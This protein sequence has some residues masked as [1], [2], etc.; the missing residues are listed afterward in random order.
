[1]LDCDTGRLS[2]SEAEALLDTLPGD[3][4]FVGADDRILYFNQPRERLFDRPKAILGTDVRACHPEKSGPTVD[5]V[6]EDLKSGAKD[7][8]E[9]WVTKDGRLIWIR[10]FAVRN[11]A[12]EYLG[13]LE[14][15][16]DVTAAAERSGR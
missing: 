12:G 15:A 10:Y 7:G 1:M 9:A 3:I 4:T 16:Q 6:L 11:P 5:R 14:F 13:C 2:S 8:D